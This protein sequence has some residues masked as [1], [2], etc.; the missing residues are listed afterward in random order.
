MGPSTRD[1]GRGDVVDHRITVVPPLRP[2]D[3][4]DDSDDTSP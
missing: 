2:G 4:H 1:D 3:R